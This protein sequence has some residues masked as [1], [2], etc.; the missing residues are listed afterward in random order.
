MH[1]IELGDTALPSH[2]PFTDFYRVASGTPN[3][4]LF[5]LAVKLYIAHLSPI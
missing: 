1:A 5:R 4:S 3:Q 2:H